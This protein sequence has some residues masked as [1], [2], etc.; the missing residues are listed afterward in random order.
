MSQ[1]WLRAP[2]VAEYHWGRLN[3]DANCGLRRG[4]WYRVVSIAGDA[5]VLEVQRKP[6]VVPRTSLTIVA[7]PPKFWT[8]VP[9]PSDARGLPATWGEAYGVCPSCRTRSRLKSSPQT[10]RCPRCKGQF[11]VDWEEWYL[12]PWI[13]LVPAI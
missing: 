1:H 2:R 6:V 11:R 7:H 13:D 4:A 5:A 9:R 3:T 10:M 8:V 12:G